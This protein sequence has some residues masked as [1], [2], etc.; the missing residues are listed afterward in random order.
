MTL[1]PQ[2]ASPEITLGME[3]A[4]VVVGLALLWR[5]DRS[6]AGRQSP[7][8]VARVSRSLMHMILGFLG[9][10]LEPVELRGKVSVPSEDGGGVTIKP[11]KSD[12]SFG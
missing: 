8:E 10:V 4:A 11:S 1:G 9:D 3:D 7:A 12:S 5:T 2:V 6:S